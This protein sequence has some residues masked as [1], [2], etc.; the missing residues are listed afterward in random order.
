MK[1][2]KP[3]YQLN[4][5]FLFDFSVA[6]GV[7]KMFDTRREVEKLLGRV[8]DSAG[9]SFHV[10]DMQFNVK[11]MDEAKLMRDILKSAPGGER[12]TLSI[13]SYY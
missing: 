7:K 3:Y 12:F 5:E 2:S 8:S 13:T 11:D 10:C 1:M 4:V 6:D 9:T